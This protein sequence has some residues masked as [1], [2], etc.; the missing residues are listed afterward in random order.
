[1]K[2]KKVISIYGNQYLYLFIIELY[3]IYSTYFIDFNNK[4]L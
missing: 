3:N 4:N 1:M 2:I